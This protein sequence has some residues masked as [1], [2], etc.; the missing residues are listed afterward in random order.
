MQV[1]AEVFDSRHVRLLSGVSNRNSALPPG[2]HDRP[3]LRCGT[4]SGLGAGSDALV[5][6]G[7]NATAPGRRTTGRRRDGGIV[8]WML[9]AASAPPLFEELAVLLVAGTLIALGSARLGVAPIVGFLAAGV[10]IGPGGVGL[11]GDIDLVNQS[12]DIGVMLLLFTLGIEFNLRR[13]RRLAPLIVGGGAIQVGLTT[14][15]V[16]M[17]VMA[18]GVEWRTALFT[19]LLVSLSSTAIVLKMLSERRATTSPTGNVSVALLIFQDLAIVAMVL[20]APLLGGETAG[21]GDILLA[22]GKAVGIVVAVVTIARTLVPRLMRSVAR[23]QSGEVFLLTI[24]AICFGTAYLTS[25]LDVSIS[26]GAFLAG[27]MVSES[28]VATRALGEVMPLQILFSAT[29]F[30]SIGMLLDPVYLVRNALVVIGLA[31]VVV[32]VKVTATAAAAA[33]LRQPKAVVFSSA[34]VLAQIGEFSFVLERAGEAVGLA[35]AGLEAGTDAFIAVTVLLMAVSPYALR[36]GDAV[37]ARAATET[38]QEKLSPPAPDP[39]DHGEPLTDHVVVSGYGARAQSVIE[40]LEMVSVPYTIVTVDPE[41]EESAHE[42]GRAVLA[43]DVARHLI[44]ERAGLKDARIVVAVDSPPE[45]VEQIARI[46]REHNPAVVVLAWAKDTADASDLQHDGLVDHVV[47]ERQAAVDA[48][49]NHTLGHFQ[50][51]EAQTEAVMHAVLGTDDHD[52][53]GEEVEDSENR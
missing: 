2:G 40:A 50:V 28:R 36:L 10:V 11:I 35:P 20:A 12:A 4:L 9:L 3:P 1:C 38:D 18:F 45:R 34:L 16:T 46:A 33:L 49:I 30:V 21:P 43:G 27:L 26:L 24:L 5:S 13:V 29:F 44:A 47:A 48:L 14:G 6:I 51:P 25:L 42:D 7:R 17:A 19:G 53:A 31:L 32:V 23:Y 37:A 39:A 41:A 8:L 15:L 22:V 52:V